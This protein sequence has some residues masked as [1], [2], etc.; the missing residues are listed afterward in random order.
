MAGAV[1]VAI[2]HCLVVLSKGTLT[3]RSNEPTTD[4]GQD[5]PENRR[6]NDKNMDELALQVIVTSEFSRECNGEVC[7]V[8]LGE[9]MEGEGV[10]V[11]P[12]CSHAFHASCIDR[13]VDRHPSCPLCRV[14]LI[15]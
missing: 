2:C 6:G 4:V 7:V 9:F 10:R 3:L 15:S 1:V 13:W 12:E 5:D 8:C 11:L 14:D